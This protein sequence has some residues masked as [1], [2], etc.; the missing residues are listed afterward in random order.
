LGLI[1]LW[2]PLGSRPLFLFI[3]VCLILLIEQ[4]VQ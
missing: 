2:G 4:S 1:D 3:L